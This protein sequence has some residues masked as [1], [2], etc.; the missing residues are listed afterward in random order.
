MPTSDIPI[1]IRG[2]IDNKPPRYSGVRSGSQSSNQL[3]REILRDSSPWCR[4]SESVETKSSTTP[5]TTPMALRSNSITA[6]LAKLSLGI[7]RAGIRF[8]SSS[9][10]TSTKE[11]KEMKVEKRRKEIE[12][13]QFPPH[14][15]EKIW[16]FNHF[17]DGFT[18]Y[19][20]SPV[21]KV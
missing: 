11:M 13:S 7:R 3:N 5:H 2:V 14:H 17:L 8:S 9:S 15:G 12:S 19:S 20:H 18:V 16:I 6:Q 1:T 21:M 4:G 10:S